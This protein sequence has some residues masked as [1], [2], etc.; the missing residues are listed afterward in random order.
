MI[1]FYH[2]NKTRREFPFGALRPGDD[3]K[4]IAALDDVRASVGGYWGIYQTLQDSAGEYARLQDGHPLPYIQFCEQMYKEE[5]RARVLRVIDFYRD[6]A[7]KRPEE[8]A[9]MIQSLHELT[10]VV[11]SLAHIEEVP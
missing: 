9:Q 10:K 4:L 3:V 7:Q 2:A 6:I 8:R 5:E 11:K 1:Y